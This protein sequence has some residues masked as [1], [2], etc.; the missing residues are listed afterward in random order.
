MGTNT[1][2][3]L[4]HE[5]KTFCNFLA[6]SEENFHEFIILILWSEKIIFLQKWNFSL[7]ETFNQLL[8]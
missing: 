5:E 6:L 3:K 4:I 7:I 1:L 8:N 2:A